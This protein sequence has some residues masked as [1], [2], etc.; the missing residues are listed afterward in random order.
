MNLDDY[1]LGVF[2]SG[3]PYYDQENERDYDDLLNQLSPE[4][5]GLIENHY[6]A[7]EYQNT[8]LRSTISLVYAYFSVKDFPLEKNSDELAE[9][10]KLESLIKS[11]IGVK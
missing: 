6:N 4:D 7:M 5:V 3:N 10:H 8:Q 2:D 1:I 9:M 11:K